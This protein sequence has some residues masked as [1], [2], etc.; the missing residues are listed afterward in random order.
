MM[1]KKRFYNALREE[2]K[3]KLQKCKDD[4]IK[5]FYKLFGNVEDIPDDKL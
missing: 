4:Q 1:N 5:Y 3:E 2:I